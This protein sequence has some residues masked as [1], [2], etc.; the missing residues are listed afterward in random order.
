MNYGAWKLKIRP[1]RKNNYFVT[2]PWRIN[3]FKFQKFKEHSG[4]TNRPSISWLSAR[5]LY[6]KSSRRQKNLIFWPENFRKCWISAPS[7]STKNFLIIYLNCWGR[8]CIN[9]KLWRGSPPHFG[10]LELV[11]VGSLFEKC[12]KMWNWKSKRFFLNFSLRFSE[13]PPPISP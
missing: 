3:D 2:W 10:E 8:A 6:Q 13:L 1:P 9:I 12:I 7:R 5:Q 4:L 11:K